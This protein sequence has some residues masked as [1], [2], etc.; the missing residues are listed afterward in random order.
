M[1]SLIKTLL[2]IFPL[3]AQY[4]ADSLYNDSENGVLQKIFLYP[5]TQWQRISYNN[6]NIE[7]QFY[8]NCS[9]YAAQSIHEHGSLSGLFITSDRIIRCSPFAQSAHQKINGEYNIDGRLVDPVNISTNS[10]NKKSPILAAGLSMLIPGLGR[11]YSGRIGDG[12]IGFTFAGLAINKAIK[13]HENNSLFAPLYIG[14]AI[15][16]YG[17]EI[18]GAYRSAKYY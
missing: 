16:L 4:P 3:Y 10:Y 14:I 15:P 2:F 8:P 18:Y 11:V 17:G 13:S 12:L 6:S 7:C 1:K 9:L 5:I